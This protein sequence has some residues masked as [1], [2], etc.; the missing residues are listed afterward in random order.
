ME[1]ATKKKRG[2]PKSVYGILAEMY[3]PNEEP[4]AAQNRLYAGTLVAELLGQKPG[5]FFITERGN[6][7]RQGIAEKIGRMYEI[8]LIDEDDA[9]NLA[10]QAIDLYNDGATV[11]EIEKCLSHIRAEIERGHQ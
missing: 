9:R 5:D 1:T 6:Y 8:G 7:R 4:R 11:K 3:Y 10:Q 2:R